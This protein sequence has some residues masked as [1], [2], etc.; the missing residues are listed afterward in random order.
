M[1]GGFWVL[2]QTIYQCDK[3]KGG[4][5]KRGSWLRFVEGGA[6]SSLVVVIGE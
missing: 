3:V 5:S 1:K 4:R 6:K 2:E